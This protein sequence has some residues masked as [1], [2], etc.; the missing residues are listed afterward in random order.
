MDQQSNDIILLQSVFNE[1]GPQHLKLL[2]LNVARP[3][4]V[5]QEN[6]VIIREIQIATVENVNRNILGSHKEDHHYNTHRKT[7]N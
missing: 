4:Q 3:I 2:N 1:K 5:V 6:L 7:N